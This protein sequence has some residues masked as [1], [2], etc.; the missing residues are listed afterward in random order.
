MYHIYIYI[1]IYIYICIR[2][3]SL[4]KT[5]PNVLRLLDSD[6]RTISPMGLGIP[7]LKI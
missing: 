2:P 1:I 4:T 6:F 3:I 5:I 7:P